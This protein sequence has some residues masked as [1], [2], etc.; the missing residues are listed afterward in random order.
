MKLVRREVE[1]PS[2]WTWLTAWPDDVVTSSELARV[3]VLR[4]A[5]RVGGDALVL[6]RT[7]VT[8]LDLVPLDRRVSDLAADVGVPLLRTLDALHLASALV[9]GEDLTAFVAYDHRLAASA[10]AAGLS[11]HSPGA[12]PT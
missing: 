5:R 6:A 8:E 11:V 10:L 4:G 1:T 12:P 3:E 7:L 2:L 9:L